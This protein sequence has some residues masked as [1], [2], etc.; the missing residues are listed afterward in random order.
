MNIE[1]IDIKPAMKQMILQA[2]IKKTFEE[3]DYDLITVCCVVARELD[4]FLNQNE[5]T[6]KF[7]A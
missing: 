1:F 2:I 5:T 3:K 7:C 4:L 6:L